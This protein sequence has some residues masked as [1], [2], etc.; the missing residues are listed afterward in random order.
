MTKFLQ[1]L[2]A[3]ILIVFVAIIGSIGW[4]VVGIIIWVQGGFE[5]RKDKM[6]A[7]IMRRGGTTKAINI[8]V[9]WCLILTILVLWMMPRKKNYNKLWEWKSNIENRVNVLE[10]LHDK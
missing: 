10:G 9:S 8:I 3:Y 4:V 1:K 6:D 2:S 5:E 7:W